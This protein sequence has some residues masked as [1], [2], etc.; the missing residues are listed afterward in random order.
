MI[1]GLAVGSRSRRRRPLSPAGSRR[2]QPGQRV[3]RAGVRRTCSAPT[4]RA[5]TCSAACS[6]GA[7]TSMAGPLLVVV[8]AM[9]AGTTLAIDGRVAG[10]W[11]DAAISTVL[12]ILLRVPGAPARDPRRGGLRPGPHRAD[13]RAGV[14]YTPYI[15]RVCA[16]PR[17]ASGRCQYIAALRGP[18]LQRPGDLLAPP[19]AEPPAPITAQAT[20]CLRLRDGRLRGDLLH[21]ARRA[22]ADRRLGRDGRRPASAGRAPGLPAGVADRRP[23]R[24][25]SPSSPS[26]CSASAWPP[27]ARRAGERAA[28]GRATWPSRCPAPGELRTVLHDVSLRHRARARRSAWSAS[29]ARASR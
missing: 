10:G 24:S 17:C 7:R 1:V 3:R 6:T 26:T 8:V 4:P 11:V 19:A 22:A 12:D 21:R 14:A 15:A 5:A 16:A 13:A 28:R 18:G 25:S 27:S 23:G 29:P 20:I 2:L 9:A